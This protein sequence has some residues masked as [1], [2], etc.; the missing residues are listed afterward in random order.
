MKKIYK[1]NNLNLVYPYSFLK[2]DEAMIIETL[3][4][5][6]WQKAS[7]SSNSYWRAD[8]NMNTIKQFFYNKIS[9]YNE[10]EAYYSK[11]LNAQLISKDY[12]YKNIQT[13]D[14]KDDIL[15]ALKETGLSH[16]TLIKYEKFLA[17]K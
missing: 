10:L 12:Y 6:N 11:M 5:L 14:Q 4:K 9:G 3:K 15:K 2:Y 17:K 13:F 16:E 7:L 8:C 1:Q